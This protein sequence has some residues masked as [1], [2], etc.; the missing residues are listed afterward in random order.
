LTSSIELVEPWATCRAYGLIPPASNFVRRCIVTG[1]R[2]RSVGPLLLVSLAALS[3]G[4]G[5]QLQSVKLDPPAANSQAQF[6]ATGTFSKPPSPVTLT[7]KDV[8]WCAGELTSVPNADPTTCVGNVNPFATVDQN[9]F[10]QC[11]PTAHG[12]GYIVAGAN[13]VLSMNPDG[14]SQFKVSGSATLTCP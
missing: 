10:A 1:L 12:T 4:G 13:Q 5:R 9:G 3:C 7:S 6:T 8:K 2:S 11:S 14:G